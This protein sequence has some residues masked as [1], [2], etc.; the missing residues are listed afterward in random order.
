MAKPGDWNGKAVTLQT[1]VK[2]VALDEDNDFFQ[3][4]FDD[5]LRCRLAKTMIETKY[6]EMKVQC[7]S[8]PRGAQI[9]L[10]HPEIKNAKMVLFSAGE[11]DIRVSGTVNVKSNNRV[12]LDQAKIVRYA[13][14]KIACDYRDKYDRQRHYGLANSEVMA[15]DDS[16]RAGGAQDDDAV[17]EVVTADAI[18]ASPAEFNDKKVRVKGHVQRLE[19]GDERDSVVLLLD[20][21]LRCYLRRTEVEKQYAKFAARNNSSGGTP[22]QLIVSKDG[23]TKLVRSEQRWDRRS[24]TTRKLRTQVPLFNRGDEVELA[25]AVKQSSANRVLLEKT[26]IVTYKWPPVPLGTD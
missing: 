8:V 18:M 11:K 16:N 23:T 24:N 1:H 5:G 20:G 2:A 3:L 7:V 17:I 10:T 13:W 21:N 4:V 25:G 26:S 15:N 14:P 12:L 6:A 9:R 19:P 22:W